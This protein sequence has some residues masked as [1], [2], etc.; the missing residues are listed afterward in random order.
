MLTVSGMRL[1]RASQVM[2]CRRVCTAV[3]EASDLELH[4]LLLPVD[5]YWQAVRSRL[6]AEAK[7]YDQATVE[8]M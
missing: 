4:Y 6:V 1:R 2:L 3:Q 5:T 8:Y 7:A